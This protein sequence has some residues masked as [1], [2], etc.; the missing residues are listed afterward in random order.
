MKQTNFSELIQKITIGLLCFTLFLFPL[1]FLTNTTDPFFIPKQVFLVILS[2]VLAAL[3]GISSISERKLKLK[4]GPFNLPVA[5]F[6]IIVLLS[7]L[8]SRNMHDSLAASIPLVAAAVV[9]FVFINTVTDKKSFVA[10]IT[11]LIAG[12]AVSSL[13]SIA[14][15]FKIY[16]LPIPAIQSQYFSTFGSPLQH[17]IY[18]VALLLLCVFALLQEVKGRKIETNYNTMFFGGA[19][20]V[21]LASAALIIFQIATVAQKPVL[22]PYAYGFQIATAAISQD[23]GSQSIVGLPIMRLLI[24][25]PFG[26]GYGTFLTDFTR[27]KLADINGDPTLWI[28]SFTYSSSFVLEVLATTGILGLLSYFFIVAEVLKNRRSETMP[29][30]FA[31][32]ALFLISFF[33]PFTIT[34]VFL[35]FMLLAVYT[36]TLFLAHDK[37]VEEVSVSIV[38][39]KQGLFAVD[40]VTGHERRKSNSIALPVVVLIVIVLIGGYL[41]FLSVKLVMA[42]T[43]MAESLA[44][45]NQNNGQKVYDLQRQALIDFPYRSDYYRIFSQINLALANSIATG[46]PEGTTPSESVQQTIS[47][48]LQQSVANARTAVALAPMTSLNWQNLSQ[49]YR[50]LIG[51]GQGADQ[52]AVA[53]LNQAIALDPNNPI[54]RVELGGIFYQL[55]QYEAAQNQFQ[56]AINL[57]PDFANA[58]YNL[59][60]ALESKEDL[61]GAV[62]AYQAAASLLPADS[63]DRK[64]LEAEMEVLLEQVGTEVTPGAQTPEGQ[65]ENQPG[66]TTP[67]TPAPT[68]TQQINISPAPTGVVPEPTGAEGN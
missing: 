3:W 29:V 4:T 5:A 13:I 53:T 48:L 57:K 34:I 49:V 11:A 39:F 65:A 21:L 63:E 43:K 61:Q 28:S 31:L 54:L 10:V 1:L 67:V 42:D 22:L 27:F 36:S 32:I 55:Q 14:Y 47:Q 51:V 2:S 41:S 19:G 15:Y 23:A 52:F 59:G 50:S 68:S 17:V 12:G 35:M 40:E 56:I 7:S 24:S 64:R 44:Q 20:V 9:Y 16:F 58:Y 33:L 6:A 62:I 45:S 46:I 18:V 38:A 8:L 30:F 66:L 60:K 25:L 26:S 37:R